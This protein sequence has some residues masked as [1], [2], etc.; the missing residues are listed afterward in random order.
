M[1]DH[2]HAS[3]LDTLLIEPLGQKCKFAW[4]KYGLNSELKERAYHDPSFQNEPDWQTFR[5]WKV[6]D[7]VK[8]GK[9][10]LVLKM[11]CPAAG[12]SNG[13]ALAAGK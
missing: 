10:L 4:K 12:A 9:P 7:V 11:L 3:L 13:V 2:L 1:R 6:T 8:R 5:V